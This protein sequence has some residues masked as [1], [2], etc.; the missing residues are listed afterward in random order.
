MV[1]Q[2]C[3]AVIEAVNKK[4]EELLQEISHHKEMRIKVLREQVLALMTSFDT[5]SHV[6]KL[7]PSPEITI[8]RAQHDGNQLISVLYQTR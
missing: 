1:M 3:D 4:R 6:P 5:Q 7:V 2:S 8:L